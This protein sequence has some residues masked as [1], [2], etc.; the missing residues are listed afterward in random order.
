MTLRGFLRRHAGELGAPLVTCRNSFGW[1]T[2][3]GA[4]VLWVVLGALFLLNPEIAPGP[5]LLMTAVLAVV[6]VVILLLNSGEVLVVCERAL[7]VG[8]TA[9]WLTPFV[10][11]YDQ[12]TVG[13]VA[14]VLRSRLYGR[15]TGQFGRTSTVRNPAWVT[16]GIHF[17]GPSPRSALRSGGGPGRFT[18]GPIRSIDGRWIWFA[19]TSSTPPAQVTALIAQAAHRAGLAQLAAATAAAQPRALTGKKAERHL[20]LPGYPVEGHSPYGRR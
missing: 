18:F 1:G 17:V 10:I 19:G 15:T 3:L 16:Q 9:L 12:I 6:A 4:F 20:L 2:A 5:A 13:S 14:P 8:P 11:R 7:V